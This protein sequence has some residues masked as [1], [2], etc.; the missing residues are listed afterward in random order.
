MHHRKPGAFLII[1]LSV[2]FLIQC[3]RNNLETGS[4]D[5][6]SLLGLDLFLNPGL[7]VSIGAPSSWYINASGSVSY[8]VT[9]AGADM[10]NLTSADVAL[11]ATGT[12]TC[13]APVVT[14]GATFTP[15][16][17]LSGCTGNGTVNIS[18]AAGTSFDA[19]GN[20]DT[21]AG[22]GPAFTVDNMPPA[23]SI[24]APSPSP[25]N[26]LGSTSFAV[27]YSGADTINLTSGDISPTGTAT[28]STVNV[29][30][31][32]TATPTV[33]LSNCTGDGTVA[34]TIAANTASDTAGNWNLA[35]GPSATTVAVDNTV[36]V[37]SITTPAAGA[38][39]N[40]TAVIFFAD[41][42][43]TSPEVSVDNINWTAAT[44]GVTTLSAIP[45]FA[46]LVQ[47]GFTLY[48]RDTDA[49]GNSGSAS[50][51]IIKDTVLPTVTLTSTPN[52]I[53]A[54][55]ANYTVSG[56]CS[57][58]GQMVIVSI[59]GVDTL[60]PSCMGGTFAA[61]GMN[62]SGEPEGSV[63]VAARHNDTAGNQGTDS[64]T[65]PKDTSGP[66]VAIG[67]PSPAIINGSGSVDYPVTYTGAD[68]INLT[69]LNLALSTT[70]GANCGSFAV[71]DGTTS[72]PIV[73]LSSCTGTGTV[74]LSIDPGTSSDAAGNFDTGA[75][76]GTA[77]NVDADPPTVSF[78]ITP[79]ISYSNQYSYS[80]TGA[81][82]ENGR[83]VSVD[84]GGI[85]NTPTCNS[86]SFSLSVDVH[87]L[88]DGTVNMTADH[89]DA[90][91]N[92]AVQA[93]ASVTKDTTYP[94]INVSY[95]VTPYASGDTFDFGNV[96]VGGS[97]GDLTFTIENTGTGPLEIFSHSMGGTN[98]TDFTV[99]SLVPGI[100]PFSGS[101]TF[102]IRFEPGGA[103]TRTAEFTITSD[104]PDSAENP[105]TIYLEGNGTVPDINLDIGGTDYSSGATYNFGAT[106][107]GSPVGPIIYTIENQGSADLSITSYNMTGDTG[108]FTVAGL[109]AT[110]I[111]AG[112]S[113]DFTVTFNPTM[114]GPRAAVLTI[115]SND[116]DGGE[117]PYTIN[118]DGTGVG[119]PDINLQRSGMDFV[120]GNGVGVTT[121]VGTP[122]DITF[123]IQNPGSGDLT[124]SYAFTGAC[125]A[126]YSVSGPATVAAGDLV[127]TF[128]I[129][130]DPAGPGYRTAMLEIS[131]NDPDEPVYYV[132]LASCLAWMPDINVKRG[133]VDYPSGSS[134]DFGTVQVGATKTVTFTIQNTGTGV[135]TISAPSTSTPAVFVTS[136]PGAYGA[137]YYNLGAGISV[138]FTVTFTP[139]AAVGYSDAIEIISNDIDEGNYTISLTATGVSGTVP[140]IDLKVGSIEYLSGGSFNFGTVQQGT[141]KT[142][143]FMIKNSGMGGL[144][145][146]L[147][148]VS[149]GYY[150]VSGLGS[151]SI[152]GGG[153]TTF[154]VTFAPTGTLTYPDTLTIVSNDPDETS[155]TVNLD[156]TGDGSAVPDIQLLIDGIEYP[157]GGAYDFGLLEFGDTTGA[158][159]TIKN[160]G[161]S[162]LTLSANP[163]VADATNF[164][165]GV[166]AST[167]GAGL[168][169]TFDVGFTPN[170]IGPL[171]TVLTISSDDPDEGT[172]TLDLNGGGYALP[173]PDIIVTDTGGD[174]VYPSGG[175]FGFGQVLI[176][177]TLSN[178][179]ELQNAGSAALNIT[180]VTITGVHAAEYTIGSG[181]DP[182]V[183][184]AN[185]SNFQIIFDP[186][187]EGIRTA[188][189]EIETDDPDEPVYVIN[190]TGI[191]ADVTQ[192]IVILGN[193]NTNTAVYNPTTNTFSNPGYYTS[194]SVGAGAHCI[195]VTKPGATHEGERLIVHGGS[196]QTTTFYNPTGSTFLPGPTTNSAVNV[197]AKS[198]LVTNGMNTDSIVL[199]NGGG[200]ITSEL[201]NPDTNSFSSYYSLPSGYGP[202]NGS[203]I[204]P[205]ASGNMLI[206]RGTVSNLSSVYD[207]SVPQYD[208]GPSLTAN[209]GGGSHCFKIL[210]GANAGKTMIVRGAASTTL[211]IYTPDP[212]LATWG[213]FSAYAEMLTGNAGTGAHSVQIF[214]GPHMGKILI[215]HGSATPATSLFDPAQPAG[216]SISSGPTL[217][218]NPADGAFSIP[219]KYGAYKGRIIVVHGGATMSTSSL[220]LST[221]PI[222]VSSGPSLPNPAGAGAHCFPSQ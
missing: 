1:L 137:A 166:C 108:D 182:V 134:Y 67:L 122:Y 101:T 151:T 60:G 2:L 152:P 16:V 161:T 10:V 113:A 94:D 117:N 92:P 44:T 142:V 219:V 163:S 25:I 102:T 186:V 80:V 154:V 221:D 59:N 68:N 118:M 79:D 86:G 6:L 85:L 58:N 77:F 14:N 171:S 33:T 62:V 12:A 91:G 127:S 126:E 168:S 203:S 130:F 28:C 176:G 4:Q 49:A 8:V 116:P 21:G 72:T 136:D 158:V 84:I 131:T 179:F 96:V 149:T 45:E 98:N 169:A 120:S 159:F 210:S 191:G 43:T 121:Y 69:I 74:A 9:Y 17:T 13:G 173:I 83:A 138:T 167:V 180:N 81:C 52:I 153:T 124:V 34:I 139:A 106:N 23:V 105:Y 95:G 40:G 135:L 5:S 184:P 66:T 177:G 73:T 200:A 199:L 70:G 147:P 110:T 140:D 189:L 93:T 193:G 89:M 27:T 46:G 196:A 208:F 146:S 114:A 18:I 157:A 75:G 3:E 11:G 53:A 112:A 90:A 216:S 64:A 172:F 145:L 19:E 29:T 218:V 178:E 192:K 222:T 24:G 144:E 55:A 30:G 174:P 103:G 170:S 123:T 104:D 71:A 181:P 194:A 175:S 207:S 99:T 187:G 109:G 212:T 35:E 38:Y 119:V 206:I 76:P 97:S 26:S 48:L 65:V 54:N 214:S 31:G 185:V 61:T 111:P 202:G 197:G 37:V 22:P 195:L 20:P 201:Y 133:T 63:I 87:T 100:I 205:L 148:S 7:T 143:T 42:E 188:A 32:T 125:A 39:V 217:M 165:T 128:T 88:S 15:T 220:D 211:N 129:T 164:S 82:S 183:N 213:S 190:L 36:P 50:R 156:G 204:I 107:L 41:S 150:S 215:I 160:N 209:V 51:N 78:T 47:G 141:S 56:T 198:F 132:D 57:E 155:Y 162:T 115:N